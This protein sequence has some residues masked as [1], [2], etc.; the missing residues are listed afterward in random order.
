MKYCK[1]AI[2]SI[3]V[4]AL[5]LSSCENYLEEDA[6]DFKSSNNSFNTISDFNMSVNNLYCLVRS[7]FYSGSEE[8][9]FDYIF[10]TDLVWDGQIQGA[11]RFNDFNNTCNPSNTYLNS[12]WTNLY[13][14]ISEVNTILNHLSDASISDADKASIEAE[15]RFFRGLSY[16]CLA[17]LYGGVPIELEEVTV[18]K[19]DY[20]RATK[21]ETLEQAISDLKF[22]AENLPDIT[23]VSDG[24]VSAPAAYHLLADVYLA[25]EEY[26][27]TYDAATKVISNSALSL[28]TSRFGS[29]KNEPGDVFYDL[30]R[31]NNQNRASG[32]TEGIW[33]IQYETGT[34]GGDNGTSS[35]SGGGYKLE[36][37]IAPMVRDVRLD[38]DVS[39]FLWPYST[40]QSGGRGVGWGVPTIYFANTIWSKSDWNDMRNSNY[41]VLR[42]WYCDNPK[43]K[44]YGQILDVDNPPC[45]FNT[46]DRYWYPYSTKCTTPGQHPDALYEDKATLKLSGNAGFTYTDQYFIRLAETYLVRAEASLGLGNKQKAADDINVVRNRAQAT[47]CT[48]NQVDIDYILDERLRELGIEEKRRLTLGRLGQVYR[49]TVEIAQNPLVKNMAEKHNLWPIP[50]SEI[51]RNKDAVLEQN[52]GY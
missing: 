40:F 20:T 22:A 3:L 8:Q 27:N 36:R 44:Y 10:G 15:T 49:R 5:S 52:P 26:Q 51:E 7:E 14:I 11:Q 48:A 6:L 45:T 47:P 30:F 18:P 50:Y 38:D 31:V 39:P 2:Y 12:H 32:N 29:L 17:Y 19:T 21:K 4:L 35:R 43:S 9:T 33:V 37:I 24:K 25:N 42:K 16:R 34:T 1:T 41:N 23:K 28:M 13:K 46:Q